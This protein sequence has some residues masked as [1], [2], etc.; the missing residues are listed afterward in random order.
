MFWSVFRVEKLVLIYLR[1]LIRHRSLLVQMRVWIISC[2]PERSKA[3]VPQLHE[4]T[5]A[6]LQW[7]VVIN[8]LGI[9]EFWLLEK[10]E[11]CSSYYN[12]PQIGFK[13]LEV[14]NNKLCVTSFIW[15]LLLI[16]TH[17]LLVGHEWLISFY[18]MRHLRVYGNRACTSWSSAGQKFS[19]LHMFLSFRIEILSECLLWET[20]SA[21]YWGYKDQPLRWKLVWWRKKSM[22]TRIPD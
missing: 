20:H 22:R 14:N 1:L 18:K 2:Q 11:G 16:N 6:P 19:T 13:N 12:Y 9:L 21:R 5:R 3:T 15:F 4:M 10:L 7:L 8:C 17:I